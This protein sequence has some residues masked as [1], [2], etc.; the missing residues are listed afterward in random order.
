MLIKFI[1]RPTALDISPLCIGIQK[2]IQRKLYNL[3]SWYADKSLIF[4]IL[5]FL[6]LFI[7]SCLKV[8]F[9]VHE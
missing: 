7:Y 2:E 6:R 1:L 3:N 8:F 5:G 9:L 4:G